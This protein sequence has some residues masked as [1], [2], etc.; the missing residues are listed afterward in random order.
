MS[1]LNRVFNI[2]KTD[3]SS[4]LS[5][6]KD[7]GK[8]T[9]TN[10]AEIEF[11]VD[12]SLEELEEIDRRE[13]DPKSCER[14]PSTDEVTVSVNDDC[15]FA[16]PIDVCNQAA[17]AIMHGYNNIVIPKTMYENA[18]AERKRLKE[19]F[20]RQNRTAELNNIGIKAEKEGRIDDAIAAYEE[21][22]A[23]GHTAYHA[24]TRLVV[25]YK[26]LGRENDKKRVEQR[27]VEVFGEK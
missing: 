26:R 22:I 11:P 10:D 20:E 19:L 16:C 2:K 25:I 8:V 12:T 3:K 1:I 24:Y 7:T 9:G 21:N 18:V 27:I 14:Q 23:I 5:V 13:A 15:I 4:E 17:D 6:D